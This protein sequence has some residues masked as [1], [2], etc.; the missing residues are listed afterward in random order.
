MD[1]F[2]TC[3]DCCHAGDAERI[4]DV[5]MD[6]CATSI[7][8][9]HDTGVEGLKDVTME[10]CLDCCHAMDIEGCVA[11]PAVL[12]A[13][14]TKSAIFKRHTQAR[15]ITEIAELVR[16]TEET[17]AQLSDNPTGNPAKNLGFWAFSGLSHLYATENLLLS[18]AYAEDDF[19]WQVQYPQ[20]TRLRIENVAKMRQ[21]V[22]QVAYA[23]LVM[24]VSAVLES[25]FRRILRKIDDQ[26]CNRATGSF[27][28][29]YK[30]LF[31]RLS[32]PDSPKR[33]RQTLRVFSYVRNAIHNNG[34]FF[35]N[36]HKHRES[37]YRGIRYRF[38]TGKLLKP[39]RRL[40]LALFRD[41]GGVLHWLVNH[42]EVQSLDDIP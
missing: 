2:T 14:G 30:E 31:G 25:T 33:F 8:C 19:F 12:P 40:M 26:A 24:V 5:A 20:I 11:E 3:I 32:A 22:A 16:Q 10:M 15:L 6:C 17:K 23:S 41:V 21:A 39:K 1:N 7:D 29:V 18:L 9:C 28:R 38:R 27:G 36:D 37:T 4:E 35:P 34:Y 13:E 42:P